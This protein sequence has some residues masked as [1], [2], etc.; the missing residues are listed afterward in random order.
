MAS[1]LK[2]WLPSLKIGKIGKDTAILAQFWSW[3]TTVDTRKNAQIDLGNTKW[4]FPI[5]K[6]TTSTEKLAS[7][8]QNW[9]NRQRYSHLSPILKLGYYSS[10]PKKCPNRFGQFLLKVFNSQKTTST[11]KLAYHLQNCPR[12]SYF[13]PISKL[14]Y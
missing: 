14:G 3:V 13:S 9:Q 5:L 6:K 10:Y 11:K 4:K 7:Q 12:Y 8:L 2:N 1:Q